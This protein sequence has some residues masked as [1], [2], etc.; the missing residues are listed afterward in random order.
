VHGWC[1]FDLGQPSA[2]ADVLG[3]E[4]AQV[5]AASQRSRARFGMRRALAQA[6]AGDDAGAAATA[7]AALA[8]LRL[9]DSATVRTDVQRLVRVLNRR[10]PTPALQEMHLLAAEALA[11]HRT[12]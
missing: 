3:A 7:C 1:L 2:A 5:P 12:S 11:A 9:V 10:R 8:D 4:L 6:M